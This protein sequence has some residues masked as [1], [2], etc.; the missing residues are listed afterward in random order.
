MPA[1]DQRRLG[2]SSVV[3]V[4]VP[5]LWDPSDVPEGALVNWFV[6]EGAEVKE[7]DTIAEVMVEKVTYQITAPATGKIRNLVPLDTAVRPGSVIAE[8]VPL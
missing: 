8:I 3:P 5:P 7:G 1:E 4:A 6:Q 2:G